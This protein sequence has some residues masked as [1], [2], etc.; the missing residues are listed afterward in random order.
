[1]SEDSADRSNADSPKPLP[2]S[3]Q[4]VIDALSKIKFGAIQLT[5]HEGKLVQVDVTERKRFVN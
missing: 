2:E 1:M 4:T 3:I 5:V